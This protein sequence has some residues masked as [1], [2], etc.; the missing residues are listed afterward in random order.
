MKRLTACLLALVLVIACTACGSKTPSAAANVLGSGDEIVEMSSLKPTT[1]KNKIGYQTEL[2]EEGEE[3]AVITMSTGEVIKLRFFPDQA[4]KAVYSF[5]KHAIQGYYDGLTFHRII[6]NFMIQGGDPEGNGTGGTSIWGTA[7]EDEF[8]ANLLNIDGSVSMANSGANTNGS[9]FFINATNGTEVNWDSYEA[10]F[11]WYK[12][13]PDV[14]TSTYGK[15]IK[16]DK[17]TDDM[18]S[19]YNQYGGNAHLDGHYS[20]NGEGHTVFAQVFEGM[21]EVYALSQVDVDGNSAP[22][23]PV[24]IQSIVITTY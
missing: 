7:F 18:K 8:A 23:E 19:L 22:L 13:D 9:Q 20:T 1:N 6:E 10:G 12:E 11:E 24:V 5:K 2:P 4:P 3:I 14:F 16:M 17:V 21:D 15:W